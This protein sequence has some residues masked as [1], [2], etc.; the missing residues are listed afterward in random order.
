MNGKKPI[1]L[2]STSGVPCSD[3]YAALSG[4]KKLL[5]IAKAPIKIKEFPNWH[6]GYGAYEYADWYIDCRPPSGQVN[7]DEVLYRCQAEP[8]QKTEPHYDFMITNEDLGV[9][10]LNFV[11]GCSQLEQGAIISTYRF[12]EDG[13]ARA[14]RRFGYKSRGLDYKSP[15]LS[16]R[17]LREL[18]I[19][20]ETIHEGG[21]VFGAARRRQGVDVLGEGNHSRIYRNHCANDGCVMRQGNIVPDAWIKATI[22]RLELRRD[23]C[24]ECETDLINYFSD[25]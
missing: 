9:S 12:A 17:K 20:T 21:H 22:D 15:P 24:Y 3:F 16:L 6:Q 18:C 11:I 7:A 23:F 8:W 4:L 5:Y 19:E 2:M 25:T 10:G 14:L 1:Y 13:V